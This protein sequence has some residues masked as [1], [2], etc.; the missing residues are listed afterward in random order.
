M[1]PKKTRFQEL[2]EAGIIKESNIKVYE[3]S[4]YSYLERMVGNREVENRASK[5]IQNIKANGRRPEP[6]LVNENMEIINGQARSIAYEQLGLTYPF[7]LFVL[8]DLH[9]KS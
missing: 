5:V 4:D 1:T 6:C 3:L 2:L 7:V 9:V 8:Y